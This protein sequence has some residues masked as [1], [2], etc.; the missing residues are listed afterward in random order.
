MGTKSGDVRHL[1]EGRKHVWHQDLH[2]FLGSREGRELVYYKAED[3]SVG[4]DVED[5]KEYM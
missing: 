1:Q 3:E 5:R 2:S 4:L